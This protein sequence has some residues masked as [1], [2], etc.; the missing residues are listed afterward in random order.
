MLRVGITGGMGSGKSTVA[1]LFQ[2]LGIPVY[3]ADDEAKNLMNHDP[4]LKQ[5]IISIFGEGAYL[6]NHLN[7]SFISSEAF[8]NPQKLTALNAVVHP[9][10]M[11]H[12]EQWMLRQTAPYTLKEAALLFESGSN[13]QLDLVIGV[14]CPMEL[15]IDR[16]MNRDGSSR[17]EVLARMQ[18]QMDEEEKMKRCDFVITNDEK[19]A[20]IP[21]VL[22][23]HRQLLS[24]NT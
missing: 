10:V 17:E 9:A 5:A 7:R 8:S 15:R 14:W 2:V 21:Q 4:V 23:L 1:R 22:S 3:F 24:R 6:S 16:V 19:V 13:K 18:K 11:A 20:V 12:G